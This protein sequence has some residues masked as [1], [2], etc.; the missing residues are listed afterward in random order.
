MRACDLRAALLGCVQ[1]GCE[2]AMLDAKCVKQVA[3]HKEIVWP[4]G[5]TVGIFL[6]E[7]RIETPLLLTVV[8]SLVIASQKHRE[9]ST[10]A[11]K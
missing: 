7:G 10:L 11:R 9:L 1:S 2:L 6:L 3:K 8:S 5:P 4:I